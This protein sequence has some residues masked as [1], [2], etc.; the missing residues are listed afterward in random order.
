MTSAVSHPMAL[1]HRRL[2]LYLLIF[3]IILIITYLLGKWFDIIF[4]LTQIPPFPYNYLIGF[5]VF[6]SGL[7][8]GIRASCQLLTQGQGLPW[9]EMYHNAQSTRLLTNGLYAYC[10]NPTTLGYTLLP[11]GMGLIFQSLGMSII[12]PI[13]ILLVNIVWLKGWEE[14]RLEQRFGNTYHQY[15]HNTPFLLPRISLSSHLTEFQNLIHGKTAP[16]S[17]LNYI[18]YT[19]FSILGVMLLI[20]LTYSSSLPSISIPYQHPIII[21]GFDLICIGGIIASVYP[22]FCSPLLFQQNFKQSSTTP[23]HQVPQQAPSYPQRGHHPDCEHYASHVLHLH[24]KIYCAGCLGLMIGAIVG[25][26]GSI[27]LLFGFSP[28]HADIFLWTGSGF[29]VLG[30]LQHQLSFNDSWVHLILNVCFVIGPLLQLQ[31]IVTLNPSLTIELYLLILIMFWIITRITLSQI[32]HSRIC[33]ICTKPCTHN[34]NNN[35]R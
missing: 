18:L 11:S 20:L 27:P 32:E 31:A 29:V 26:G 10:R 30:I 12:I 21:L 2:V 34:K 33:Q 28:S 7:T 6:F 4:Q 17:R 22:T 16:S 23:I 8:I 5:T 25:I 24:N 3:L 9:G 13:I 14:P 1:R 15:R 19:G 35:S